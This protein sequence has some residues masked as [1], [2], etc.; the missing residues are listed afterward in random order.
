MYVLAGGNDYVQ[1]SS[2]SRLV[3]AGGMNGGNTRAASSQAMLRPFHSLEN[4]CAAE[5][6]LKLERCRD[7]SSKA[8]FLGQLRQ[9]NIVQQQLQSLHTPVERA[10]SEACL[11]IAGECRWSKLPGSA[12]ASMRRPGGRG[13]LAKGRRRRPVHVIAPIGEDD[14]ALIPFSEEPE[15]PRVYLPAHRIGDILPEAAMN[16]PPKRPQQSQAARN[17]QKLGAGISKSMPTLHIAA[18]RLPLWPVPGSCWIQGNAGRIGAGGTAPKLVTLRREEDEETV[19][20]GASP[21]SDDSIFPKPPRNS[22]GLVEEGD[23]EYL[24]D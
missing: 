11:D 7:A 21:A 9:L 20:E 1:N 22:G 18:S 6:R 17:S 14:P 12:P 16:S 5:R 15:D 13:A 2:S 4:Q 19:T 8:G 10:P 3:T 24:P 23:E